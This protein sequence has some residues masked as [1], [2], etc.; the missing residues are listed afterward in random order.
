MSSERRWKVFTPRTELPVLSRRGENVA[1]PMTP[2][3]VPMMAPETPDFAGMPTT[4]I[5]RPARLYIPA[6]DN[7]A[8]TCRETSGETTRLPVND[9]L[10]QPATVL[11]VT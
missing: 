5:H 6:E 10:P 3:S 1:K 11:A 9:L 4:D 7:T 8:C 2:G